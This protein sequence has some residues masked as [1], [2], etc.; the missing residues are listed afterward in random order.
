MYYCKF[1]LY[2]PIYSI[3]CT[4]YTIHYT[5]YTVHCT[6]Y[7]VYTVRYTLYTAWNAYTRMHSQYACNTNTHTF[8]MS[9]SHTH[10]HTR[11][12]T[13]TCAHTHAHTHAHARAYITMC[14]VRVCVLIQ[15]LQ[16][17]HREI[18]SNQYR[19]TEG[20]VCSLFHSNSKFYL[21]RSL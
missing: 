17:H 1:L 20:N 11:A 3:Q 14:V 18:T 2:I 19:S 13:H 10:T 6:L 21:D 8:S 4:L 9:Q 7:S 15:L 16:C 5:L 12:L